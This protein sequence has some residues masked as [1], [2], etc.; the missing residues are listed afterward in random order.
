MRMA[1][2]SGLSGGSVT[3]RRARSAEERWMALHDQ[4]IQ[5]LV[6]L[7]RLLKPTPDCLVSSPFRQLKTATSYLRLLP[8]S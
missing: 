4:F 5:E 2:S 7:G 8:N 6:L 3:E 1:L